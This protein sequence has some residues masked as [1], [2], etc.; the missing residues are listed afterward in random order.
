MRAEDDI[1]LHD[2]YSKLNLQPLESRL[3]LNRLR[4]YGHM[5]RSDGWI[6]HCNEI[7]IIGYQRK[8][9]PRNHGKRQ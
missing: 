6:K 2:M 1:S 9:R 7:V 5:E 3:R 4:W 8:G